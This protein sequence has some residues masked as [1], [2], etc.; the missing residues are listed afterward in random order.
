MLM[1]QNLVYNIIMIYNFRS[2]TQWHTL[3]GSGIFLI[4]Y[5][6]NRKILNV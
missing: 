6:R 3:V 5:I 1:D 4:Y 2:N